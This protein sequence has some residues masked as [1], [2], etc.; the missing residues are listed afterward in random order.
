MGDYSGNIKELQKQIKELE[1]K[2]VSPEVK[3]LKD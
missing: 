3:L 2:Q 1:R